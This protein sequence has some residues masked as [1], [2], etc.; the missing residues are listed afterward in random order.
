MSRE[1]KVEDILDA[2]DNWDLETLVSW[3]KD[4]RRNLLEN[5]SDIEIQ[6]CWETEC[7]EDQSEADSDE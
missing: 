3:A 5:L 1:Q 2:M 6:E 7:N 4:V